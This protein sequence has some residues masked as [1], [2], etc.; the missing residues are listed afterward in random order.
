MMPQHSCIGTVHILC[1]DEVFDAQVSHQWLTS[2]KENQVMR[3]YRGC[4]QQHVVSLLSRRRDEAY[5]M[6]SAPGMIV[7]EQTDVN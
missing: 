3:V 4:L 2:S 5:Q 7:N 6:E 1:A